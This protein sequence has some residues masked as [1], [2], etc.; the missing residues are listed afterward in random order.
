MDPEKQSLNSSAIQQYE[1]ILRVQPLSISRS[2]SGGSSRRVDNEA[3][4]LSASSL[5]SLEKSFRRKNYTEL[6][7]ISTFGMS[8]R[9][10]T[11]KKT[12]SMEG[13]SALAKDPSGKV[14]VSRFYVART[15]HA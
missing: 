5:N 15:Y 2:T 14:E 1:T 12:M 4:L 13:L 10:S 9:E 8:T 6:P 3:D 11:V 7:F